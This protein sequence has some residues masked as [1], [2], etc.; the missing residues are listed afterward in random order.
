MGLPE[1]FI[2]FETAAASA[3]RRSS[4][5]VVCL[6]LED[7]T[8]GGETVQT[9]EALSEVPQELFTAENYRTIA[10]A[11]KAAPRKVIVVRADENSVAV[12]ESLAFDWLAAPAMATDALVAFVK[13]QRAKGRS[14]KAVVANAD[15]PDCEGIVNRCVDDLV[16]EDGTVTAEAYT[17]RIAGLLA[18][19]P[20]THS[21]TYAA[22][23]EVVSCGGYADP[24]EAV[25]DGKLIIVGGSSGYR[26]GRAVTSLTTL[27]AEKGAPFQKIKILEGIDL[28]RSDIA[29]AFESGYVGKVSNDYDSKL[30]LVTAINGYLADLAGDVLDKAAVN[31]CFVSLKGQKNW[32][33]SHGVD[34]SGMTDVAILRTNTGSQ[35]FL[36]ASLTFCDAME[37]LY[38]VI[39]M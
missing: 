37:D 13:A 10:L 15:M 2:S 39:A 17:A 8:A 21:A 25:H 14:V 27:T 12:L 34:T 29:R 26:L 36:E 7:G 33:Q 22:L 35:V 3:I 28:I 31:R 5:G 30:L 38:L 18:A 32:L 24:D 20:L 11:F 6:L 16:L 9:Y 1:I 4:R 23:P 19:L